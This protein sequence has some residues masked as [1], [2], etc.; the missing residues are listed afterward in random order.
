MGR[1]L[2]LFGFVQDGVRG[3]IRSLG[4]EQQNHAEDPK[5]ESNEQA[6]GKGH[7]LLRVE[8]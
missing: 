6:E 7:N 8:T 3:R 5:A 1:L 2:L 4:L